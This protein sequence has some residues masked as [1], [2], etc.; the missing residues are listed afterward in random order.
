M[1]LWICCCKKQRFPGDFFLSCVGDSIFFRWT[2]NSHRVS[3][4]AVGFQPFVVY[5]LH[6]CVPVC[7]LPD[8][9]VV[10]IKLIVTIP[11]WTPP[12]QSQGKT[13]SVECC[14]IDNFTDSTTQ[15]CWGLHQWKSAHL[16]FFFCVCHRLGSWIFV[17]SSMTSVAYLII[18]SW[19][20]APTIF[21]KRSLDL[22]RVRNVNRPKPWVRKILIF[23]SLTTFFKNGDG[24]KRTMD[25]NN[26]FILNS[27]KVLKFLKSEVWVPRIFP[28]GTTRIMS[29]AVN[30]WRMEDRSHLLCQ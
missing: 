25:R 19:G 24:L 27:H 2:P 4:A 3:L 30:H 28:I 18:G 8:E 14:W 10:V 11:A 29:D 23:G 9:D 6:Y 21:L 22:Y 16:P 17:F 7:F 20:R 13:D 1:F 12:Q 15:I 26:C 5:H